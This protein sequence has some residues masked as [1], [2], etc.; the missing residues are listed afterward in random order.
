MAVFNLKRPGFTCRLK[1]QQT[2]PTSWLRRSLLSVCCGGE[3]KEGKDAI[4]SFPS[5]DLHPHAS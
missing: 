1:H 4:F 5:S 2:S 3:K